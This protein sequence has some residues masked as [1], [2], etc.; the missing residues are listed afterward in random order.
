MGRQYSH[1]G[2]WNGRHDGNGCLKRLEPAH[3]QNVDEDQHCSK[4]Q[5]EIA[6]DLI[7]DMLFTIPLHGILQS[8]K[9]LMGYQPF[10]PVA[11]REF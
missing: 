7:R 1:Q 8:G 9:R 6:E 11:F 10:E 2:E 4:G 3:N 5:T